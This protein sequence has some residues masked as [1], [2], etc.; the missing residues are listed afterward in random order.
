[1]RLAAKV[2]VVQR[3]GPAALQYVCP[4]QRNG[5]ECVRAFLIDLSI[6]MYAAGGSG[7]NSAGG[8]EK[9][10]KRSGKAWVPSVIML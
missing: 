9:E 10:V 5:V 4:G 2:K 1:M 3:L 7:R 6:G 8:M